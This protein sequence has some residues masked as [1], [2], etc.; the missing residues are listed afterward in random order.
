MQNISKAMKNE[1]L[2]ELLRLLKKK[3][4]WCLNLGEN[5]EISQDM[6]K[7]FTKTLPETNI[8]H[9]Y[10]S[11]HIIPIELKNEMRAH[12]RENRKKHVKHC[13]IKNISV[14]ERCTHCW[15]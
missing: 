9:L 14:I 10:V 12:I 11:E 8:T 13:S 7:K 4:I 6:W 5:Y 3:L 15:W 1:Q 2:D